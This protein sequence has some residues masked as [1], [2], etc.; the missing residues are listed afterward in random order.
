MASGLEDGDAQDN[1]NCDWVGL[2]A[3]VILVIGALTYF[4]AYALGPLVEQRH[5]QSGVTFQ[6]SESGGG[7]YQIASDGNSQ[8]TPT[9]VP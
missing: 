1:S 7:G 8:L 4:P 3:G 6:S 5:M 2:L 9:P